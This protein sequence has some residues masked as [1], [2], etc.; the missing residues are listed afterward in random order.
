MREADKKAKYLNKCN[1][2][3]FNK[4]DVFDLD[5]TYKSK[6]ERKEKR[7][8]QGEQLKLDGE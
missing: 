4:I 3:E 2:F 7:V 8:S 1:D 5:K 6:S